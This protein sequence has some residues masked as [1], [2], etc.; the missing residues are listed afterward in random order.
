MS[1]SIRL[2]LRAMRAASV[3]AGEFGLWQIRKS[4][5]ERWLANVSK[6][7]KPVCTS[8][9]RYTEETLHQDQ[10]ELVMI[11]HVLELQ[12]HLHFVLNARGD[13]LVTGLGLG[14]VVRGL[15][16]RAG[17]D[18]ITVIERDSWIIRHVAPTLPPSV[19]IIHADAREWCQETN[20][21]FDYAWHDL[22]SDPDKGEQDLQLTHAELMVN[23]R[24]KIRQ[25]G[26]WN[27]PWDLKH[28]AR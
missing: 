4:T 18:T 6:E 22:W 1:P 21:T 11:D 3:D 16:M 15:S 2:I 14:C 5:V 20:Q 8:L 9:Y 24:T 10:G 7:E 17:V 25:Q 19:H 26:A 23:L 27:F 12:K 28:F 13:V